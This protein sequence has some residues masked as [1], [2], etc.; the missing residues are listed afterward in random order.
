MKLTQDRLKELLYYDPETGLFT[1]LISPSIRVKA[2]DK[3]GCDYGRGYISIFIDKKKYSAHRLAF[4]YITGKF[5]VDMTD[6]KNGIKN[7]NR[8]DNLRE[9]NRSINSQ[10]MRKPTKNNSCGF[11]GVYK[12]YGSFAAQIVSGGKKIY[13]GTYA[14]AEL[15]HAVYIEAKR[16]LHEGNTL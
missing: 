15:A 7:D 11:L 14:S 9:A 5:P 12:S 8:W 4:L 16:R 1:W 13:L 6:H 10:N 2:G 3:A